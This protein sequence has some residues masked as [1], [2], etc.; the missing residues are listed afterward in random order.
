[1]SEPFNSYENISML[2]KS[3]QKMV[4][5]ATQQMDNELLH[6]AIEATRKARVELNTYYDHV[7]NPEDHFYYTNNEILKSAEHQLN[8]A[9]M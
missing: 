1:M 8:E 9:N 2:V 3:A 4:G 5:A 7:N 6:E